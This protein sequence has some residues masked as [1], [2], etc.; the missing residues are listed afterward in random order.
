VN[1]PKRFV[2]LGGALLGEGLRP[3]PVIVGPGECGAIDAVLLQSVILSDWAKRGHCPAAPK[4]AG[5][6]YRPDQ[7]ASGSADAALGS[8]WSKAD[9]GRTVKRLH[10]LA[11]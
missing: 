8:K 4:L 3:L 2:L 1:E 9:E 10:V 6:N 11:Q 5:V 7:I